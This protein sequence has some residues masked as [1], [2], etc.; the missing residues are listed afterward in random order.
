MS[1]LPDLTGPT[2]YKVSIDLN[3]VGDTA[4]TI[5][6]GARKWALRRTAVTN[7]ST[8]LG[9]SAAQLGVYTAAAAGGVALVAPAVLT[10][11]TGATIISDRTNV[12]VSTTVSTVYV[13][14]TVAHGSAATADIY[15]YADVLPTGIG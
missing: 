5:P 3:T 4:V 2:A 1:A 11:L 7:A 6:N 10:S 14:V 9:A 15:F 13:R 8:S 12:A